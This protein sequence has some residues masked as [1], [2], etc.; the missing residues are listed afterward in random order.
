MK[1]LSKILTL[2][3]IISLFSACA[4]FR[5]KTI[6]AAYDEGVVINGI[7]W[8]TRNVDMPGTFAP[9]PES[10]GMF[11]QW[12]RKKAWNATDEQISRWRRFVNRFRIRQRHRNIADISVENWNLTTPEGTEWEAQNDPCPRGWRV[13][14][15][16]ELQNLDSAGSVWTTRN[17][18]NGRVFGTAPNQIFLPAAGW[19]RHDDGVFFLNGTSGGYWSSTNAFSGN[20][21]AFDFVFIEESTNTLH[22]FR[23]RG[24]SIRC[25]AK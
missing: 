15:R 22:S 21:W 6:N 25:V 3:I 19:R 1:T 20:E 17:G 4:I 10:P 12:N 16:A 8:A 2:G 23:T 5:Q 13:P 11:Y 18:I 7:R 14:T 9:T 24:F